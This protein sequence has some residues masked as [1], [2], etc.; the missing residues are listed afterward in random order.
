MPL[1]SLRRLAVQVVLA[2]PMRLAIN[3]ERR[4]PLYD[5]G[6]P[7]RVRAQLAGGDKSLSCLHTDL[8]NAE[9]VREELP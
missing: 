5:F 6:M 2:A 9:P 8:V 3:R 7:D 1:A 4:R